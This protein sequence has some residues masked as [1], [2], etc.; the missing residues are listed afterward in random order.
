FLASV[1]IVASS[2]DAIG[3][4][5][6]I[7]LEPAYHMQHSALTFCTTSTAFGLTHHLSQLNP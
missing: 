6:S 1:S 2:S 5:H 7:K 4:M 3:N